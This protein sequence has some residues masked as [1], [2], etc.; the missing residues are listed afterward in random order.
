LYSVFGC[1]LK[2]FRPAVFLRLA[3]ALAICAL[4]VHCGFLLAQTVSSSPGQPDQST[5]K[6]RAE[7]NLVV[8][9]V[10]VRDAHG[11]AVRDLGKDDF[12]V[13][14]NGKEQTITQFSVESIPSEVGGGSQ[15][16]SKRPS[17]GL[18][19][20]TR[21]LALYFDDLDMSFEDIVRARDAADHF[22][23]GSLSPSDRVG[24]FTST[25]SVTQDFTSDLKKLHEALLRIKPNSHIGTGCPDISDYQAKMIVEYA[26]PQLTEGGAQ[27]VTQS[28]SAIPGAGSGFRMRGGANSG[29]SQ[30]AA[31]TPGSDA[32][33]VALD[34]ALNVCNMPSV[35]GNY[36]YMKAQQVLGQAVW[37]AQYSLEGLKDVVNHI[38]EMPGQ[39][40]VV[41]ISPGFLSSE[42]GAELSGIVDRALRS[43]VV[44]SSIDAKGLGVME[45]S[46]DIR[47]S[48]TTSD[49][50]IFAAKRDLAIQRE[51][52]ALSV[53]SEVADDTGG[54]FFH[55]DN[56]L[57]LGLRKVTFLSELSYILAF[58]PT[59]LKKDGR[60]HTLK[61]TLREKHKGFSLQARRGYFAPEENT[62][63]ADEN[64]E[65]V[66]AAVLSTEEIHE[67]PLDISTE[68]APA[69]EKH[70]GK[71]EVAFMT[72]LDAA[73]VHFRKD[74][75]RNIDT[76]TF[77]S[78]V[79][80]HDGG[81]MGG[82][83]KSVALDLPDEQLRDLI[84]SP[85]LMVRSVF[86][87]APGIYTIREVVVDSEDHR[88]GAIT[89]TLS[90]PELQGKG[91]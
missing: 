30:S 18:A 69:S 7:S 22:L 58:Q 77:V 84:A 66:R 1:P 73:A 72:R 87:L 49:P 82:Q 6:L 35:T 79:F 81:W 91:I 41:L 10:M 71:A 52:V 61:V 31:P 89:R 55:N 63:P 86:E 74:G 48:Y 36:I 37:Q 21:F 3:M 2:V 88:L 19:V 46:S 8:V 16:L 17:T 40:N 38:S 62:K 80:D 24:I 51:Q 39:R 78:C 85:G 54:E 13:F 27:P 29:S 33:E 23:A 32:I 20:P 65:A 68:I 14:D 9:R 26:P 11:H 90:V 47:T 64:A 56:D 50:N 42:L 43:Q 70:G 45:Q 44:V 53:M 4:P 67:L 60:F 59:D 75:S 57:N 12:K 76:L 25:G 15:S 28:S 34:D 5:F 83:R